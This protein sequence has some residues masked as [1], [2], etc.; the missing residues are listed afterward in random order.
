MA[1]PLLDGEARRENLRRAAEARR[2]RADLKRAVKLGEV[3]LAEVLARAAESE[4]IANL[5]VVELLQAMPGHGPSRA[6]RLMESLAIAPS[7]RVRG[8]GPRQRAALLA[9]VGE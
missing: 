7:R 6:A 3:G 5:R 4:P 2:L 8:L 9:A 1:V